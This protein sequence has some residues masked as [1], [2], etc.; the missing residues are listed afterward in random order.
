[1]RQAQSLRRATCDGDPQCR[2][3]NRE[4]RSTECPRTSALEAYH[5]GWTEEAPVSGGAL[6]G[7]AGHAGE[8][9][10]GAD[11]SCRG[12]LPR[13]SFDAPQPNL[14][15]RPCNVHREEP[16]SPLSCRSG[17]SRLGI[18][19]LPLPMPPRPHRHRPAVSTRF[20]TLV[21]SRNAAC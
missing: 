7:G 11:P 4:P 20:V 13:A 14:G 19:L 8:C 12:C 2:A 3:H 18:C 16:S 10:A 15:G 17:G 9:Q 6:R 1:M 5:S 21:R